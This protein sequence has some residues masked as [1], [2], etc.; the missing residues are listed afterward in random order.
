MRISKCLFWMDY[1]LDKLGRIVQR[2]E[3]RG[4]WRWAFKYQRE[5]TYIYMAQASTHI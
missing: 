4:D 5:I 3:L 1:R 2:A